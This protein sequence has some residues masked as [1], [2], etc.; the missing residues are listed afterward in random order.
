MKGSHLW[1]IAAGIAVAGLALFAYKVYFLGFPVRPNTSVRVWN[2]EARVSFDGRNDPVK[3]SLLVPTGSPRFAITGESFISTGYGLLVSTEERNRRATWSI[4]KASGKQNLYYQ[5]TVRSVRTVVPPPEDEFPAIV[6]PSFRGPALEAAKALLN[7]VKAKSAD[8]ITMVSELLRRLNQQPPSPHVK[9]LIGEQ[10]RADKKIGIAVR[11]LALD[12]IAARSVHGI[13]LQEEHFDFSKNLPLIHWIEVYHKKKWTAFN[14]VSGR[15][16][17][18]SDWLGWWRGKQNP[19][20]IVGGERVRVRV[21]ISPRLEEAIMSAMETSSITRPLLMRFSLFS[22]PVSTQNVYRVLLMIPVGAFLLA[23]ARN[24]IGVN[25]FGTFMPVLIGLSFRDTGLGTG[26]LLFTLVVALGLTVRFWLERLKLLLVPR[27]T[28]ILTVVVL[29]MGVLSII[30]N[31]LGL[32]KGLSVALFPMVILTMTIER[33]S[34]VWEETGPR[35][36]V[37]A[38]LGSLVTAVAAYIVMNIK[39][40]D[41]L[42]FVFPELLLVLLGLTLLLGRYSGYRLM[43]LLR[44]RNLARS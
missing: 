8:T 9:A 4:R 40:L 38:G 23:L 3:V 31:D 11:V 32:H 14:P 13:R 39:F 12:G 29:L 42:F 22:L 43:D 20:E 37:Y 36:A 21:A 44:F 10:A 27:L 30:T 19:V 2:I 25:T 41:H 7:E 6:D 35:E 24:V 15:P 5:A 34:I 16:S 18:P 17:V 33:M 1:F 28:A 26:I